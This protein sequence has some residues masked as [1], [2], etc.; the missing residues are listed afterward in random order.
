MKKLP[1]FLLIFFKSQS[2]NSSMKQ[3]NTKQ[4]V[5]C[6]WTD[7]GAG[8][9]LSWIYFFIITTTWEHS[10]KFKK[11]SKCNFSRPK[12]NSKS[13][14]AAVLGTLRYP[15]LQECSYSLPTSSNLRTL[16]SFRLCLSWYSMATVISPMFYDTL[17]MVLSIF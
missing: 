17:N 10:Q 7:L 4:G 2:V 14:E 12:L 5:R 13:K 15:A 1:G 16:K 8:A 11:Y 3:L 6:R 9:C